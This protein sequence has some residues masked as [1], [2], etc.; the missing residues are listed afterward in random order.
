[1]HRHHLTWLRSGST[2]FDGPC[3]TTDEYLALELGNSHFFTL[4]LDSILMSLLSVAEVPQ[5]CHRIPSG[6]RCLGLRL[7]KDFL[8]LRILGCFPNCLTSFPNCLTSSVTFRIAG[9]PFR[10]T[11]H[12]QLLSESLLKKIP[13]YQ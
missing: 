1:M 10:I 12:P 3:A 4:V 2:H 13:L 9:H 5:C 8:T 11:L 7:S 6:H